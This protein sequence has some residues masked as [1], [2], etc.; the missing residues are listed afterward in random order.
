M[1][2]EPKNEV[3]RQKLFNM[4]CGRLLP[5]LPENNLIVAHGAQQNELRAH[6]SQSLL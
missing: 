6:K 4:G 5:M 3:K 2:L 1:S